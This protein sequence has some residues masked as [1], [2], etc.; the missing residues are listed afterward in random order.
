MEAEQLRTSL[1]ARERQSLEDR[2]RIE[3]L[4]AAL[5]VSERQVQMLKDE[6][7]WLRMGSGPPCLRDLD[8]GLS[9]DLETPR[10]NVAP[11]GVQK[12]FQGAFAQARELRDRGFEEATVWTHA[13]E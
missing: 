9:D 13:P 7:Q 5:E 11:R 12:A 2:R 3:D 4:R 1:L 8:S 6:N 10:V